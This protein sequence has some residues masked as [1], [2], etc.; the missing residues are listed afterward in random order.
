MRESPPM[1]PQAA[2]DLALRAFAFIAADAELTGAM[3][4]ASGAGAADLRAMSAR[5]EFAPF[6]LDILLE[7]DARVIAFARAEGIAPGQ[8]A[9]ARRVLDP[10][11]DWS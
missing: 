6:V 9:T 7:E 2:R 3:L 4:A 11:G 8:V 5:P 1:S 10:A